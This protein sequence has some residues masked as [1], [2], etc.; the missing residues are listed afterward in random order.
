[1]RVQETHSPGRG[2]FHSVHQHANRQLQWVFDEQVNVIL[3][4]VELKDTAV[5]LPLRWDKIRGELGQGSQARA[6]QG[7]DSP[8]G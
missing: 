8:S 7:K 4:T 2:G 3:F 5:E 6:D 1:M